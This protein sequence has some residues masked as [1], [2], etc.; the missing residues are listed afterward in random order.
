MLLLLLRVMVSEGAEKVADRERRTRLEWTSS[1]QSRAVGMYGLCTTHLQ[2]MYHILTKLLKG[3][4]K[5][6]GCDRLYVL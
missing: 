3:G 5:L 4:V 6:T 2:W 1:G